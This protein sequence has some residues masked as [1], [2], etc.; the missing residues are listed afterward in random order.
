MWFL[1][2]TIYSWYP[3]L[4]CIHYAS[5]GISVC[6]FRERIYSLTRVNLKLHDPCEVLA[7][8]WKTQ[9][10]H[11]LLPWIYSVL[12]L[13]YAKLSKFTVWLWRSKETQHYNFFCKGAK[14][15]HHTNFELN[16]II[17]IQN[18]TRERVKTLFHTKLKISL[19]ITK[20]NNKITVKLRD[21]S[22][23]KGTNSSWSNLNRY[24]YCKEH[25]IEQNGSD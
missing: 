3:S 14:K 19:V 6:R 15:L 1:I 22:I 18:E 5:F 20:R 16:K 4:T 8:I 11:H 17:F 24:F 25:R 2:C 9:N 23:N 21:Y 13:K 7:R 10:S 12:R